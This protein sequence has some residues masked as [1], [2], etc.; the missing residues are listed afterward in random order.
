MF[1][2]FRGRA[3]RLVTEAR[4][5]YDPE[6]MVCPEAPLPVD[7]GHVPGPLL[8]WNEVGDFAR[9]YPA[10]LFGEAPFGLGFGD[11]AGDHG[12]VRAGF[13]RCP[14]AG[15]LGVALGDR[16]PGRGDGSRGAATLAWSTSLAMV[17]RRCR[18]PNSWTSQVSSGW[19]RTSSRMITLRGWRGERLAVELVKEPVVV[20]V[21]GQHGLSLAGL[22][23]DRAGPGVVLAGSGV[24]VAGGVI[25][26]RP[27]A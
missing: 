4:A 2:R 21:A 3:L 26:E 15:E 19:I 18:G 1:S 13:Q 22:A 9:R 24:G 27:P 12:R 16:R 14:V 7:L 17:W 11:P 5:E 8:Q 23:G 25:A 10:V 20:C 6:W